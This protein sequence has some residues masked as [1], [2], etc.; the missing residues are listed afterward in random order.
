[1][2]KDM[3][4][5]TPLIKRGSVS[6]SF[7]PS[8][9]PTPT[10]SRHLLLILKHHVSIAS[11]GERW[12]W[13]WRFRICTQHDR[14]RNVSPAFMHQPCS[15]DE[16]DDY[17]ETAF[18]RSVVDTRPGMSPIFTR[19]HEESMKGRADVQLDHINTSSSFSYKQT[20]SAVQRP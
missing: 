3:N 13:R 7:I 20:C 17:R 6:V 8:P 18:L 2:T 9:S 10:P 1:M 12:R 5:S 4:G 19:H 15:E 11:K 14:G 16:T